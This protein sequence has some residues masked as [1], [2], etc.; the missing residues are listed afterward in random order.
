MSTSTQVERTGVLKP[1]PGRIIVRIDS[2]TYSGRLVIPE[3]AK[4]M[5]TTGVVESVGDGV[6]HVKDG[7]HIVFPL[8]SGTLVKFKNVATYRILTEQEILATIPAN[9]ELDLEDMGT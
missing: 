6:S 7:D 5:P 1:L 8:Y 3:N 4:R 9:E 2:F